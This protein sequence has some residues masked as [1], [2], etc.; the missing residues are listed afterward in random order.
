[1][2]QRNYQNLGGLFKSHGGISLRNWFKK[3]DFQRAL[4]FIDFEY[5]FYSYKSLYH[6][7]PDVATWYRGLKEQYA[8]EGIWIFGDFSSGEIG[9]ELAN[10]RSVTDH[11]IETGNTYP[12]RKKDM[13]D[14]VMLDYIYRSVDTHK[15]VGT[16]ILFTGDGHFQSAVRYLTEEKK[17][18]VIVYGV[19][20]SLSRQLQAAATQTIFLPT[21]ETL[22][23]C[24]Y[25]MVLSNMNYVADKSEIIPT[26]M[27]TVDAVSRYNAVPRGTVHSTL[28]KMV[29][30][31]Y[32]YQK[33]YRVS[34]E[35]KIKIIAVNWELVI[36]EG[37][38]KP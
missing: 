31:G 3:R 26:F 9:R 30:L 35:R 24:Y 38:W 15:K 17:K 28:S 10:L 37:L 20:N 36:Q 4:V 25:Q 21:E 32:I 13:T 11:I 16:Y 6:I 8:I 22:T 14:F 33:D 1:M 27:G 29:D 2:N 23:S 34:F 12:H 18:K 19:P 5:W 7:K